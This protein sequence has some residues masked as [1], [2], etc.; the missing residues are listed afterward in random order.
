M[1]QRW[2]LMGFARASAR[3]VAETLKRGYATFYFAP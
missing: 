1:T 2:P 3:V